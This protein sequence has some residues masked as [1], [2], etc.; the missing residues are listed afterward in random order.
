MD[1]GIMVD[2]LRQFL[3]QGDGGVVGTEDLGSQPL[4]LALKM[5]V[6]VGG[7][8]MVEQVIGGLLLFHEEFEILI[9]KL[10][11]LLKK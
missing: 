10:G 3:L 1:R 9:H 7:G 6:Q 2:V 8:K 11:Y 5:R 4:H